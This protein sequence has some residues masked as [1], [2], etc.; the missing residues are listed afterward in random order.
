M[1]YDDLRPWVYGIC[2]LLALLCFYRAIFR[3]WPWERKR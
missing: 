3:R 1:S 2:D